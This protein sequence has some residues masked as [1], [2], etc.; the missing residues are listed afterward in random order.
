MSIGIGTL[1]LLIAPSNPVP[2]DYSIL[3]GV[4]PHFIGFCCTLDVKE[5]LELI[6]WHNI[7]HYSLPYTLSEHVSISNPIPFHYN[8]LQGTATL[9]ALQLGKTGIG[10]CCNLDVKEELEPSLA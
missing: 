7:Q 3:H 9:Q 1:C 5:E 4:L 8:I 6:V 10:C 2:F